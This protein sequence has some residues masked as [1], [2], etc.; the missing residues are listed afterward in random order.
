MP[1]R[2]VKTAAVLIVLSIVASRP[3]LAEELTPQLDDLVDHFMDVVFGQ[4]YQ[5]VGQAQTVL[6]RW[7]RAQTIGITI[8][9]R[10]TQELANMASRRLGAVSKLTG[11][12][13]QQVK[14]GAPA[15]SIDLLFVRRAEMGNIQLPN[16]DPSVVRALAGD[17]TMVCFFLN[18]KKPAQTILKGV[19]VVNV[20]R[21]PVQISSCLMEELTQVMGLPN[22]VKT[23]WTTLFNPYDTALQYSPWDA[24]Y[25]QTLYGPA[26]RPGMTPD[27]VRTAVRPV[28]AEALSNFKKSP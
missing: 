24:L 3:A 23:Y 11:V 27:Q 22:D 7:D 25:L 9:G 20:E 4:E 17:P 21:D 16:T 8:Q 14:P 2:V 1:F 13:F 18:W 19:V 5:G 28:F 12:K 26:V 10:A 15:P 6:A